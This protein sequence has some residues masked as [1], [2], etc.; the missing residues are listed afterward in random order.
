MSL[1][2][3]ILSLT[4]LTTI[5]VFSF[6]F[7]ILLLAS[8]LLF[9]HSGNQVV[10]SLAKQIEP[11]FSIVLE[12]GSLFNSP[13][14]SQ[15]SWHDQ[16]A[17]IEIDSA[18]YVFD[19]SC[20]FNKV[21]LKNLNISNAQIVITESAE[22]DAEKTTESTAVS[23][24]EF[25][26]DV[27]IEG[28]NLKQIHFALGDLSVDL[29]ELHLQAYAN[30]SD[31]T[32]KTVIDGLLVSL[33]ES[34]ATETPVKKST[35]DSKLPTSKPALLSLHVLPEII[36]PLNLYI[37]PFD[38]RNFTLKQGDK[39]LFELNSL[40]SQFSFIH[41]KLTIQSF[42]LDSVE[43]E[44]QLDGAVN[45]TGRYPLNMQLKGQLKAIKQLQ[46]AEL[47]SG[48]VYQLKSSGDLSQLK[49]ELL[50]SNKLS[51]QLNS[52]INLF[53]E[54][55]PYILTLNWQQLR[56][57]L[58]GKAQYSS[59]NGALQSSGD[60]SDYR[61]KIDTV[62]NIE[63]IP[64]GELSLAAK[65]DL[66]HL[67]LEQLIV[68]TL[69]GSVNL[70]GLLNW[71]DAIKWQGELAID[72]I[73]LA[74]LNTQYTGNFSGLIKQNVAV[75]LEQQNPP[76]WM[77]AIPEMDIYGEFLTRPFTVSG[78]ISGD[79]KQ[80]ISFQEVVVNNAENEFI[81]NGRL[82]EQNDLAIKLNI[83]DLSH[84]L[85]D[86]TGKINGEV[87]LQGPNS[88]LKI[89]SNLQGELL[90][91]Q[92]SALNSFQL[93]GFAI[94]SDRPQLSLQL[95]AKELTVAQQIID[96]IDITIENISSSDTAEHHQIDLSVISELISTDLQFQIVQDNKRWLSTLSAA[97]IDF[98]YQQLT[99]NK[100]I[101]I[102]AENENVQLTPH[103]WLSSNKQNDNSG[104]LCFK[105]S[106]IGKAGEVILAIDSYLLS[107][108]DPVL[109]DEFKIAGA[110]SANA[111]IKWDQIEKPHFDINV[112]SNDMAIKVNLEQTE[113][114]LFIYPMEKFNL[115]LSS[116][117][118]S[119]HL[120]ATIYSQNLIDAKI[121]G[122]LFPYKSTPDLN[123]SVNIELPDFSP[124]TV[125]VPELEKLAGQLQSELSINGPLK[126]PIV[127]GQ[128]NINDT[129]ITAVSAP[130]QIK[131]LNTSITVNN[132]TATVDGE[133]YTGQTNDSDIEENVMR[134]TIIHDA[135]SILD[136]SIKTV[137]RTIINENES[138]NITEPLADQNVT[139]RANIK[140]SISWNNKLEGDVHFFADKMTIYDYDKIDFLVSPDLH[141]L[142]AEHVKLNGTIVVN[143]GKITVK[144]LPEG[145]V[146]PSKDIIVVDIEAPK[147]A[148]TLPIEIDLQVELGE[149]LEVEALGLNTKIN[150]NMLIRKAFDQ[151]LTIHGELNLV[152]GSYRALAQ[153]LVLQKSRIVF[154]GA[155]ESPYISI[156]A[157][158]DPDKIEDNVTAGVRV[159]GTP[160]Q[161]SLVI[162][163]DPAMAQQDA[164]S[165]IT[166][167]KS[168]QASSDNQGN[169]QIAGMLIDMGADK[170]SGVMND[171][172]NQVGIK[173]LS[174]SSSGS[175]DEQSVGVSGSIAPGIELSYGVGV[176]DS[177]SILAIR[178]E[179]FERFYIEASS[180]LYQAIDAYYEFDWE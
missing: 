151:N 9:S 173:D 14:Y 92:T 43:T 51:M 153:Q 27:E 111:Q 142:I 99:L 96:N 141:L 73:D 82:A 166:R 69:D 74:Q 50:L 3:K 66:Q 77:F 89:K 72:K 64:A 81:I 35:D 114:G 12:Q 29:N 125:L 180:G 45:F 157:I 80:G 169:S 115:K 131:R 44:L 124:F 126:N 155:P 83:V 137:G 37:D 53:K 138:E 8:L 58:T 4:K 34:E 25:P 177:F 32:L 91:Y 48:Q 94:A 171:I 60:I 168:L 112:F 46:P 148:T 110:L 15:I 76:S 68:N 86:S 7:F 105:K 103:C 23:R 10:I 97:S 87:E 75:T 118:E 108:L 163:S 49:T 160:D 6:T 42:A 1:K 150:G 133:F 158:R 121:E 61:I 130:V 156:E 33:P 19:W 113:Q 39:N 79:D 100:P 134:K 59:A 145:A 107:S 40:S 132:S 122:Q 36:L 120:S 22:S 140:G 128:I 127:N 26:V 136:S 116:N 176:F 162:F 146:S 13:T 143:K 56:W 102:I 85:L 117:K 106:D 78:V 18:S 101:D 152:D 5:L 170:T 17:K 104:Q 123:L 164:L 24:F 71:Q 84:A 30:K 54:N 67:N 119:S 129:T 16:Q 139:G 109:P 159:T 31:L 144:E 70:S 57:P 98:P 2:S 90:S 172:G 93:N 154:Q 165:Y 55:L 41:S 179:M 174:L 175:G 88:A 21:C 38:I 161:L 135:I 149:R 20:L 65:G 52:E 47:L 147:D 63:N 95:A 62:Y 11:R 28:I 167:G 178:Y